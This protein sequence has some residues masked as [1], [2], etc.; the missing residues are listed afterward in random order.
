MSL[1]K[2]WQRRLHLTG[3]WVN[4]LGGGAYN[5][6]L[7]LIV[8][9][10]SGSLAQ[11]SIV[12]VA[13]QLPKAFPGVLIG[14]LADRMS[15]RVMTH[16]GYWGQALVVAA[17]ALL[18]GPWHTPFWVLVLGAFLRG[19]LDMFARTATFVA[20]PKMYGDGTAKFNAA[21]STAWTSA[22]I[23][24]PAIGGALSAV[25]G[26]WWLLAVDAVSFTVIALIMNFLPWPER[27]SSLPDRPG[28]FKELSAG[29]R[30]LTQIHG[31]WRFAG[32]VV[33][34]GFLSAPLSTLAIFQ[35]SVGLKGSA[36]EVGIVGAA[37]AAGLFCGSILSG[38][39]SEWRPNVLMQR[40]SWL[41]AAGALLFFIPSWIAVACALFV[42]CTG[43][44]AWTVGRTSL[45]HQQ[46]PSSDLG[47]TM[48]AVQFLETVSSPL[49]LAVATFLMGVSSFM[50]FGSILLAA[51][52]SGILAIN[53]D[54]ML[55]QSD[56][57]R[58]V[59]QAEPVQ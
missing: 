22:S 57:K 44:I 21:V 13:S 53:S 9:Q 3:M 7:P 18:I 6:A 11:M 54:S 45:I 35:T 8:L 40:S 37:A 25:W 51:L 26:P 14:G 47:K 10:T 31:W 12:A 32:T 49:S 46:I 34:V 38:L 2:P 30:R 48:T 36:T 17:M 39:L 23:V 58:E 15:P 29:Y 19:S 33:L 16:I 4:S 55:R 5:I 59:K 20:I 1:A 42:V 50:A 24:G 43:G 52:L 27:P 56:V 41:M 28:F